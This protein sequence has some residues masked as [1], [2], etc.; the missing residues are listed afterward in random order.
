MVAA[1]EEPLMADVVGT[2]D[3]WVLT[4]KWRPEEGDLKQC[5]S[6]ID[7]RSSWSGHEAAMASMD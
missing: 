2:L 5:S 3:E 1:E 7:Q 4:E 6:E